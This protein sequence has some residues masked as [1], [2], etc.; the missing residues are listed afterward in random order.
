VFQQRIKFEADGE[1][2]RSVRL[3]SK[4]KEPVVTVCARIVPMIS[5][6]I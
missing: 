3:R 1:G 4:Q 6:M 2:K 5:S